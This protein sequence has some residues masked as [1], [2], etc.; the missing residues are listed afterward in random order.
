[1]NKR[2]YILALPILFFSPLRSNDTSLASQVEV[3][4]A[5]T[6]SVATPDGITHQA[7]KSHRKQKETNGPT[8]NEKGFRRTVKTVATT[9]A[10]I[11]VG[12]VI[13]MAYIAKQ[14]TGMRFS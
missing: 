2:S 14:F 13:G 11:A 5:D 4:Q 6:P 10:F 12:F 7:R 1:M 9:V 3:T 8:P